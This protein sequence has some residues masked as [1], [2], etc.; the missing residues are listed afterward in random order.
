MTPTPIHT[1]G[2]F[3]TPSRRT[4]T[5][6]GGVVDS[7]GMLP[8]YARLRNRFRRLSHTTCFS[9]SRSRW[10]PVRSSNSLRTSLCV[11]GRGGCSSKTLC[12]TVSPYPPPV[13]RPQIATRA[14]FMSKVLAFRMATSMRHDSRQL[15]L[16]KGGR[17]QGGIAP[18]QPRSQGCVQSPR[19]T[20]H[21]L[22]G[23]RRSIRLRVSTAEHRRAFALRG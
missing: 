9:A 23:A 17:E 11:T 21:R 2:L 20:D 3:V 5:A 13:P 22:W 8:R 12:T 7:P 10:A 6:K 19:R 14:G 16:G 15:T 18:R 4:C 1:G